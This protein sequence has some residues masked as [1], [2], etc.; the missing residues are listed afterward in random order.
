MRLSMYR[1]RFVMFYPVLWTAVRNKRINEGRDIVTAK[2][3]VCPSVCLSNA[4]CLN[5]WTYRHTFWRS[6]REIILAFL[7][8]VP[9]Q[10]LKGNPL[11]VGVKY[12]GVRECC[13]CAFVSERFRDKSMVTMDHWQEVTG[14]RSIHVGS[15]DLELP[16]KAWREGSWFSGDLQ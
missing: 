15:D 12:T 13:N 14:G 8:P 7:S 2:P 9:L 10:N 6:G 1:P 3:S 11:G 4:L 5:E 16:W